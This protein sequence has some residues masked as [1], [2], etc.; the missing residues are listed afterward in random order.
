MDLWLL[1]DPNRNADSK[2]ESCIERGARRLASVMKLI[3]A[4]VRNAGPRVLLN[5]RP[6][7]FLVQ[8]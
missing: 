7:I 3:D 4:P 1:P 2:P 6:A 5:F 8:M